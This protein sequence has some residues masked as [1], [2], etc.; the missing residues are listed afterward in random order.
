MKQ[1][2]LFL[3]FISFLCLYSGHAQ[4]VIDQNGRKTGKW[5]FKGKDH[6]SSTYQDDLK[7]EEGN[8]INGRKEGF[9]SAIIAMVKL[10]N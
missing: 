3:F 6:P 1:N 7:T 5:V 4:N 10:Q 2:A 9:G 8:F